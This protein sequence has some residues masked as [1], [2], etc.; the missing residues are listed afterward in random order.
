MPKVIHIIPYNGIGGVESAARSVSGVGNQNF[1]FA[2]DFIFKNVT[3]RRERSLTFN[4]LPMLSAAW[5]AS[6][7]DVDVVVVSLWRS[8]IVALIAKLLRRKL[9][10]VLFLHASKDVNIFDFLLT[11][12]A[13]LFAVEV[14]A[15]SSATLTHRIPG[16]RK[17]RFRTISFVTKRFDILPENKVGPQFIFWGRVTKQKGLD[18]TLR[19]FA[20]IHTR[21]P[22]ARFQII[23]PDGGALST[24]QK[25]CVSLGLKDVVGF[26]G[27]ATHDE[28]VCLARDSS[29]YLQTSG[30]EGMAMSVVES[31][32]MGLV[33]VVTAVGEI[34][35]YCKHRTNA[36][37]V[38]SDE[39][40]VDEI[41]E[42]L[43][44][45][46][47][48]QALRTNAIATWKDQPLY[49]ESF[50][51]ACESLVNGGLS[52]GGRFT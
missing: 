23:G 12:L 44:S 41:I 24:V 47:R 28:I 19:L 20:K 46:E 18:R 16:I 39:E 26:R 34:A 27:A 6:R 37:I 4:P 15:D 36:V 35:S 45:N 52:G 30:F 43:L 8:A 2:I 13:V 25:L 11:R 33:P 9:K 1:E 32:Q 31:M 7:S 40:V 5:R 51:A 3:T 10:F 14:W 48:Y 21:L 50:L 17:I 42:L 29:F 38:R 49:R 22:G